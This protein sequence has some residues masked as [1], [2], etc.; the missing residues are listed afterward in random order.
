MEYLSHSMLILIVVMLTAM[1]VL[2]PGQHACP[3][4]AQLQPAQLQPGT[5]IV[6]TDGSFVPVIPAPTAV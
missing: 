6:G 2:P 3:P 4:P 1:I 5:Y